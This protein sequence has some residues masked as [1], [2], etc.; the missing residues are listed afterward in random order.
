MSGLKAIA[1]YVGTSVV[2]I[3]QNYC[4]RLQLNLGNREVF[5]KLAKNVDDIIQ[6]GTGFKPAPTIPRSSYCH[7][8]TPK[9][10]HAWQF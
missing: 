10:F 3:E 8:F 1:D 6:V 7:G 9:Y 2:I 5:E 4:A